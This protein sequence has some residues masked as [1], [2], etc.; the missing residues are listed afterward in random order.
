MAAWK[1]KRSQ[2]I[3]IMKNFAQVR[4]SGNGITL[5]LGDDQKEDVQKAILQNTRGEGLQRVKLPGRE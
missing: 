4:Q 1:G 5:E 3:W 2:A